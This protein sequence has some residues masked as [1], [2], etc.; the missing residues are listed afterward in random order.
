M[1]TP[2]VTN[3]PA[4]RR[5]WD[6]FRELRPDPIPIPRRNYVPGPERIPLDSRASGPATKAAPVPAPEKA[7]GLGAPTGA[8][9]AAS[10]ARG[11]A[12]Q[13]PT[14]RGIH[15]DSVAGRVMAVLAEA[16]GWLS[17]HEIYQI[18][19]AT[20]RTHAIAGYGEVTRSGAVTG[21]MGWH[22][23]Q[24]RVWS[25]PTMRPGA[26]SRNKQKGVLEYR[27]GSYAAQEARDER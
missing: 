11:R 19:R 15:P 22:V 7:T 13:T 25:R 17:A 6:E 1:S 16:E 5:T 3:G 23:T 26:G 27:L 24:G 2:T 18:L 8:F 4:F 12:H 21:A 14:A 20:G 9:A 10:R